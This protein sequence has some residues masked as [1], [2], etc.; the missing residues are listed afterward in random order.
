M[1][2][3]IFMLALS[4]FINSFTLASWEEN[5]LQKAELLCKQISNDPD[6]N[7]EKD[8]S[9]SYR[10]STP[11]KHTQWMFFQIYKQYG[12][13]ESL[14]VSNIDGTVRIEFMMSKPYKIPFL[15]WL[16]KEGD[17]YP[18]DNFLYTVIDMN[19]NA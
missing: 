1:A 19:G 2:R 13:C 6:F 16:V 14:K 17:N 11:Y 3:F 8:F 10:K 18:I 5:A 4:C 9:K 12:S 15:V 7:Y